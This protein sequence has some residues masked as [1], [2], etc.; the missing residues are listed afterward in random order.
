MSA[1]E[2]P[3]GTGL[4]WL[5]YARDDVAAAET[6]YS[7]EP[8]LTRAICL[9]A[10]QATEK[11]LK[12]ALIFLQIDFPRTHNLKRLARLLTKDW[13]LPVT[14]DDLDWLTTWATASRYPDA[15][16]DATRADARRAV[17]QSQALLEA[18]T[19]GLRHEGFLP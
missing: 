19:G 17:E 14:D 5:Q 6:L 2:E 13:K 11:G 10:Q 9:H 8:P 12:A 3:A 1:S 18:I 15:V 4:Q 7:V 16:G